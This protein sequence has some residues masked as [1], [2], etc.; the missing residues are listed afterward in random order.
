M[1]AV[2][3][4]MPLECIVRAERWMASAR[5][6]GAVCCTAESPVLEQS[7]PWLRVWQSAAGVLL[8]DVAR[9]VCFGGW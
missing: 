1:A 7:W 5:G 8:A 9:A 4:G 6:L 3:V 2:V